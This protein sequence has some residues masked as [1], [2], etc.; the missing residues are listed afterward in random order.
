MTVHLSDVLPLSPLAEGLLFHAAMSDDLDVYAVQL[1]VD[2]RGEVDLEALHAA[3]DAVLDRHELL[4]AS[5]RH[6]RAGRPVQAIVDGITM[7][8]Q[9]VDLREA[10]E[11][12]Q[13]VVDAE[14]VRRFDPQR[15]PLVRVTAIRLAD[16]LTRVVLTVH[17]LV[18]D[19]WSMPVLA[20]D[21][22]ACYAGQA[23]ALPGLPRYRD[24]LRLLG[25][26]DPEESAAWWACHLA[27][28]EPTL[29][30]TGTAVTATPGSVPGL[31]TTTWAP[32]GE[33]AL[34]QAQQWA[35]S[36]GL[37]PSTVVHGCWAVAL[38]ADLGRRDVVFGSALSRRRPELDGYDA[39][40]GLFI[41]TVPVAVRPDPGTSLADL[42]A[43]VAADQRLAEPHADLGLGEIQQA[44][45]ATLFDS[46]LAYE[47]YPLDTGDL[48]VGGLSVERVQGRDATHYPLA[49][50]V[51]PGTGIRFDHDPRQLPTARA[52]ALVER[53]VDLLGRLPEVAD[54][55]LATVDLLT[56]AERDWLAQVG[57]GRER[58]DDRTLWPTLFEQ[59]VVRHATRPAVR[60]AHG[61]LD[62][63]GLGAAAHRLA[64]ELVARGVGPETVV[65]VGGTR[66]SALV[67]AAV[68]VGLTGA[69]F[70]PLDLDHPADRLAYL[71][72][73]TRPA[74]LVVD[75][76][77]AAARL[78]GR[79]L[80]TLDVMVLDDP[81]T[82]DRLA[83]L[84]DGPLGTD[85]L[86]AAPGGAAYVIYTSGSTGR[87]KGVVLT[88]DALT[89]TLLEWHALHGTGPGS[90]L[91]SVATF[92]FDLAVVDLVGTVLTGGCVVV[93][94]YDDVHDVDRLAALV[95][96]SGTTVMSATA[97]LWQLVL[98]E[99][100][101][102]V[103]G[104]TVCTC[105]EPSSSGMVQALRER[106]ARVL[107]AYGPAEITV[108]A[109]GVDMTPLDGPPPIGG[110]I[111]GTRTYV[112][113][114]TLRRVPPGVAG[115]LYIG[116]VG[117]GRGYLDR[118]G[119]TA[120]R[121]VA[122]PFGEPGARMYRSGDVCVIDT[123]GLLHHLGRDDDQVKL[124][125]QRVELGEID[126]VLQ[127]QPGVRQAVAHVLQAPD[128]APELVAYL[129]E[130]QRGA[131][132]LPGLRDRLGAT[133][134]GYMVPEQVVVLDQMPMTTSGKIDRAGLPAPRP[135]QTAVRAPGALPA[136]DLLCDLV[137]QEF[138]VVL[139]LS[140][141]GEDQDFFA[142]GGQ[143][144]T[145]ARLVSR[146]RRA[147]G[148]DV[149]LRAV[150]EQRTPREL[151]RALRGARDVGAGPTR[152][153]AVRG[154]LTH[155][156]WRMWFL[157]QMD[158]DR[159]VYNVPVVVTLDHAVDLPALRAAVDDLVG[160]H[161]LLR[162]VYRRLPE[163]V[164]D[165]RPADLVEQVVLPQAE[166]QTEVVE[167]AGEAE[168]AELARRPFDLAA[169]PPVRFAVRR[170]DDRD[171]L[172]LVM[173]HIVVDGTSV[174]P[175]L[176]DLF[177]A[178]AARSAGQA[179][180]RPEPGLQYLDIAIWQ[181]EQTDDPAALEFWR[182]ALDDLPSEL[183]L[184]YDR[185]RPALETH[186]G[187]VVRATFP[188]QLH[189]RVLALAAQ[190]QAT[191]FMVLQ[192]TVATL[193]QTMAAGDDVP[194]GTVVSSRDH[195]LTDDMVGL[196]INTV[197]L[198]ADLSGNPTFTELLGRVRAA[199]LAAFDH[200]DVP[201][202][203]VID[204]VAADRGAGQRSLFQTYISVFDDA[205][206]DLAGIE[207]VSMAYSD[208]AQFD[209]SFN[210]I[211]R[212]DEQGRPIGLDLNLEYATD[213]FDASTAALL[214][215][216]FTHVLD[217]VAA[218]PG[219]RLSS[220][221][222]VL[223]AERD[224]LVEH[225]HGPVAGLDTD[226]LGAIA[227]TARTD[228]ER[229]A[230]LDATGQTTVP[231]SYAQ[232]VTDAQ[233]VAADLAAA[234]VGLGDLV[235]L[236]ALPG[237]AAIASVLGTWLVGAT[238]VSMAPDI[239]VARGVASLRECG[240][241]AVL[242]THPQAAGA[243]VADTGLPVVEVAPDGQPVLATVDAAAWTFPPDA[244]G[245][246]ALFTSGTTGR[247][248]VALLTRRGVAN[249]MAA[250]IADLGLT[251]QD[252]VAQNGAITFDVS[253]WQMI[254][255]L[256]A[257][258]RVVVPAREVVG[259]PVALCEV[260][261][262][263]QV[264]VMEVVPSLLGAMLDSWDHGLPQPGLRSLRL[265]IST[266]EVLYTDAGHR[267]LRRFPDIPLFSSYGPTEC[268]DG[269]THGL[270]GPGQ[271][272]RS[273]VP[274]GRPCRN[275]VGYVL[276]DALRLCPPGVVGELYIA[277]DG[278]GNGY[279]GR[280]GR[281]AGAYVANPFVPGGRMYRSGDNVCWR[282]DGWVEFRERR[283]HQ[284]KIR[285]HRIELG[286]VEATL[287]GLPGVTQAVV[288]ARRD[289]GPAQLV[290]YV[291][292]SASADELAEQA[293]AALP[294]PMVPASWVVMDVLPLSANGK[295]DRARLP[296]PVS[297]VD[298]PRV[299]ATPRTPVEEL[300][301]T[302]FAEAVGV[303]TVGRDDDFFAIGGDSIRSVR[304]VAA[305]HA[306]GH[307]ISLA[308]LFAQPTPAGLAELVTSQ[309]TLAAP[310]A[311]ATSDDPFAPVL[312][313]Q[314]T[315]ERTPLF[316]L[317]A[318][319][320]LAWPYLGLV[321][322][323]PSDQPVIG[324]Q[325]TGVSD[326]DL[327]SVTDLAAAQLARVRQ[328]QPA[329]PYRLL[330]WS[331]GG[332]LVHEMAVQLQ[333]V[334]EQV[335]LVAVL[336]MFP[337]PDLVPDRDETWLLR[338]ILTA[339]S[340]TP[341][342]GEMEAR[343]AD[344]DYDGV[345][346][347]CAEQDGVLSV[348][349]AADLRRIVGVTLKHGDLIARHTPGV[350]VGDLDLLVAEPTLVPDGEPERRWAPYVDGEV[351]TVRVAADHESLLDPPQV[352]VY[353]SRL[354]PGLEAR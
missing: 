21:L 351:R 276:D 69:A 87:P 118:P 166:A 333:K 269:V 257:G 215:E 261:D 153:G 284:V 44:V 288:L 30:T 297:T 329:G 235:A 352:D 275:Y 84:P 197:V 233:A 226:V 196:F 307:Q 249:H 35:R 37:T 323:L 313:L 77:G 14:R 88:H 120:Q 204:A 195:G 326:T 3:A 223:P 258:G 133:L 237:R 90:R 317:H 178:Y 337:G 301:C 274:M 17:H 103:D 238:Y 34:A 9:A 298:A 217:Q 319:V 278:V 76:A 12:A 330:G 128:R 53:F 52:T 50:V 159:G 93:A 40:V 218:E 181:Q 51:V 294:A 83:G 348:F 80:D 111:A 150:F 135:D 164:Q 332:L 242:T 303:A 117:V 292:A 109:T 244:Q 106:A 336:D 252:V 144:L 161:E 220:V 213:L 287:R 189:R 81:E 291:A 346:R 182:Q 67:V 47:N 101:E 203:R 122:D 116:G 68:A 251:E 339:A 304:V 212:R 100:P 193:Y 227:A 163:T 290:A 174:P 160:R 2:L 110:P 334:G 167:V 260:V 208:T 60:D 349:T 26:I 58:T 79:V 172:V 96:G 300:F 353:A 296:R 140:D 86:L 169:A 222:A 13:A 199:D 75:T 341:V 10:P 6:D 243:L 105:G 38:G 56:P 325:A 70:L 241:Q 16:D 165:A 173:H 318:G 55:P 205:P 347:L 137:R 119:L 143:S 309:P 327:V 7:P 254:A 272:D 320:G 151:A 32:G 221:E 299:V 324:L 107:N 74:L 39:M 145:A 1:V 279:L 322:H 210:F 194:L 134:P 305:A 259:D 192:A 126:T 115:D 246:Y 157:S 125:G 22:L 138:A 190:S 63:A 31:P 316:C 214:V 28:V 186:H 49:V 216:R 183:S 315:G 265:L 5:F 343:V 19:G 245:S 250:K 64:R 104:L 198:R 91:L 191:L 113:D 112:L 24:H 280:P 285:G 48:S 54:Q 283:D 78:P 148:K 286:D 8:W 20:R 33:Q 176:R 206:G 328:I 59:A 42:F 256:M 312:Y 98:D 342:T 344:R 289:D 102:A 43:Q 271:L 45:G 268:A 4:R 270:V 354:L 29:L 231:V 72:G 62:Y 147:S 306:A 27:G 224:W 335:E 239:P 92:A 131:V 340:R 85:E 114:D 187:A 15:P 211:H 230:V 11:Q 132:D 95:V 162:T 219:A 61:E 130:T 142:A 89:N 266:G 180:D 136:D 129:V 248:K 155:A 141:V 281:T 302:A 121:F 273:T 321:P 57:T 23:A 202:E 124:R 253:V 97:S 232:L 152:R 179:P 175:L 209:L 171:Q 200:Q 262:D 82:A 345:A 350:L 207:S 123:D 66:S 146:L 46:V 154:P 229:V 240:P 255:A 108:F 149:P 201:Y 156:Q 18:V 277:G 139:G 185:P 338:E 188:E 236:V 314:P 308:Q 184:P 263:C 36:Q 234:G 25:T 41:N 282:P 99:H 127:S 65:A 177:D 225:G 293:R 73:D 295:V 158:A 331:F 264:T 71:L 168:V 247:P 310:W 267:W 94:G 170:S 311:G 228:P